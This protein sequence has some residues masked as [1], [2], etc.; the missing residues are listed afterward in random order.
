MRDPAVTRSKN[1]LKYRII[2]WVSKRNPR[3]HVVI[4]GG[5]LGGKYELDIE[6]DET[7]CLET[8]PP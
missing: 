8:L 6:P 2:S 3:K 7:R 1:G 4:H 5:G